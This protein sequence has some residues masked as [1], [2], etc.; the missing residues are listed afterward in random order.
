MGWKKYQ[1]TLS[2]KHDFSTFGCDDFW[3]K[4]RRLDSLPYG[5]TR[6]AGGMTA[7]ELEEAKRDPVKAEEARDKMESDLI[8]CIVD[9]YITD[10]TIQEDP[11]V[12]DEDKKR[13]M[14][15]PAADDKTP[16]SKLP[17]EFVVAM[18][19]WIADDSN[20]AKKVSKG[21][22]TSSGRP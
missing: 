15:L 18:I 1:E 17:T 22:G 8:G 13:P 5:E 16:L 20:I 9:W 4:L 21:I 19:E 10:P 12:S 2:I 14:P 3:V 11:D 6:E 7:E